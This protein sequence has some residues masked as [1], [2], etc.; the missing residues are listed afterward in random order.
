MCG[1]T[2]SEVSTLLGCDHVLNDNQTQR[3][4]IL[5]HSIPGGGRRLNITCWALG[6]VLLTE[7]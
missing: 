3:I 1:F 6:R 4:A 7:K 5:M 2:D